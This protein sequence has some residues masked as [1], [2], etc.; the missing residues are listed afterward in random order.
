M[1]NISVLITTL[2]EAE[3]L[4]RCLAALQDFDDITVIDSGSEDGTA[5]ISKSFGVRIENFNWNGEYPKKR[6]WC[7]DNLDIKHDFIFCKGSLYLER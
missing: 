4:P 2:N 7:L 5:E 3:N 6:Q 1:I